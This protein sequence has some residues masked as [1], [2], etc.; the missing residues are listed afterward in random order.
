MKQLFPILG[1][2]ASVVGSASQSR[3]SVIT[4]IV[5]PP[6]T[7]GE[8]SQTTITLRPGTEGN[9]SPVLHVSGDTR[10]GGSSSRIAMEF[11][12]SGISNAET[13]ESATFSATSF[14]G[15]RREG[16]LQYALFGYPGSGILELWSGT[17]GQL[18]AGPFE[19]DIDLSSPGLINIDVTAFVKSMVSA[20]GGYA[21]FVF[22]D[23]NT[24]PNFATDRQLIVVQDSPLWGGDVPPSLSVTLVPEPAGPLLCALGALAYGLRRRRPL[25][26]FFLAGRG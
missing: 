21:G 3:A 4:G 26:T 19:Y 22:R 15:E 10:T 11:A 23:V 1:F 16:L 14:G 5:L 24:P 17:E 18:L 8:I 12:L 13:I 25:A 2:M 6:H 20:G 7:I 9:F